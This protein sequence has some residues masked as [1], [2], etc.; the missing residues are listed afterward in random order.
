METLILAAVLAS[1]PLRIPEPAKLPEPQ[2]IDL[3][4]PSDETRK[5]CFTL[6]NCAK[7]KAGK[8]K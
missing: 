4:Q 5:I 3:V 1:A 8:L 2:R 6:T 7:N